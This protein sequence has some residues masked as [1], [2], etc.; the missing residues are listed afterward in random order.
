MKPQRTFGLAM[1]RAVAGW[2]G[3]LA[4]R[5]VPSGRTA[6]PKGRARSH[7]ERGLAGLLGW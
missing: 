1:L 6:W 5:L 2:A 7:E 3:R 4:W